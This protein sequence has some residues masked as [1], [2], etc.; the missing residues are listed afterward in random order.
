MIV[1]AMALDYAFGM[2]GD[3]MLVVGALGLGLAFLAGP[4]SADIAR[5]LAG[6][7]GGHPG[8]HGDELGVVQLWPRAGTCPVRGRDR[9]RRTGPDLYSQRD[10]IPRS[11][12]SSLPSW[13]LPR[14]PHRLHVKVS[15]ST[16][17]CL[18]WCQD[19]S[20]TSPNVALACHRGGSDSR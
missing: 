6:G 9:L 5:A 8:S 20:P 12:L 18:G 14:M 3:R 2:L 1:G 10:L 19:R 11:S 15:A 7:L 16:S 17:S 13:N 4:P